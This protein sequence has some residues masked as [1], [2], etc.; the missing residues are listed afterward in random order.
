MIRKFPATAEMIEDTPLEVPIIPQ[1]EEAVLELQSDPVEEKQPKYAANVEALL[2]E[3]T[4]LIDDNKYQAAEDKLIEAIQEDIKCATAYTLLGD[5]CLKRHK[6]NEAEEAYQAAVK[7]DS[8]EAA[9]HF[10]LGQILEDAGKL[11][12]AVKEVTLATRIDDSN[13]IWYFRLGE[14]YMNL[15]MYSKAAMAYNRAANLRPDYNRYKELVLQ[16]E[17]KQQSHKSQSR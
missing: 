10:G 6:T 13:D 2:E 9:A 1:K 7:H 11:N 4:S 12:E 8:E 14:L 16:A 3:A 17:K 5:I 15:R